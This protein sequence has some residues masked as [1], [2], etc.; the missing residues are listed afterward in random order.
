MCLPCERR[1][2]LS[3]P[4]SAHGG[5]PVLHRPP[6]VDLSKR[7]GCLAGGPADVKAHPFFRPLDFAALRARTLPAPIRSVRRP[8][9]LAL[10]GLPLLA[11]HCEARLESRPPP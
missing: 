1:R 6:Q 2:C 10:L 7:Y 5:C 11:A 3:P 8:A 4:S 9:L